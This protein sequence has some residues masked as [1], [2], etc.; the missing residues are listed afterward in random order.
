MMNTNLLSRSALAAIAA[1]TALLSTPA[2]GQDAAPVTA[3]PAP[4]VADEPLPTESAPTPEA[5]PQSTTDT[6][7]PVAAEP[8]TT[9]RQ[10]PATDAPARRPARVAPA[11]PRA[12]TNVAPVAASPAADSAPTDAPAAPDPAMI[13][14]LPEP[15]VAA[16]PIA[17]TSDSAVDDDLLPIAGAAGL[18]M[19]A[20]AGAGLALR[21]R[22]R[23]SHEAMAEEHWS[24]PV[25]RR[26]APVATPVATP[27]VAASAFNWGNAPADTEMTPMPVAAPRSMSRIDAAKRGP[28]PDN[29]SL[30]LKK[31]LKRAAFFDQRDRQIAA[32]KGVP[33][34]AD[35][36]LPDAMTPVATPRTAEPV[37]W[38]HAPTRMSFGKTFQPA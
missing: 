7:A 19:L 10:A 2:L 35:A 16:P 20:L 32:G 24:E 34:A 8:V 28:T 1:A 12:A 6:L 17:P 9:S 33:I 5:T 37:R 11:A 15:V 13:A 38:A 18:G 23:I 22:R 27:P 29:P 4:I 36:G 3:D 30:S 26:P 25:M 31:R 14:P 21:R